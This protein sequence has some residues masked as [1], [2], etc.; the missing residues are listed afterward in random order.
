MTKNW[1]RRW[2]K[3]TINQFDEPLMTDTDTDYQ[4]INLGY[5]DP[6]TNGD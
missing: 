6:T 5:L 4:S 3:M 1:S 2:R